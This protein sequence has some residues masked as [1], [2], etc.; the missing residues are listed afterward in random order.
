MGAGLH[1]TRLALGLDASVTVP[2]SSSVTNVSTTVPLPV[3]SLILKYNVTPEFL[4][5]LKS[6]AFFLKF[7][8]YTGSYRDSTVGM[9][10]RAWKNV[11]LG[12]GFSSNALEIEEDDPNY[13]LKFNNSI[14]GAL[15]YL[16]TYF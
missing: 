5:Y 4:W 16:A 1:I 12:A 7:D 10:Y 15:I 6:E 14:S 13:H 8:N 2:A 11:A 3:L 9:E